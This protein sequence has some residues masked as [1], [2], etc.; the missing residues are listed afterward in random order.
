MGIYYPILFTYIYLTFSIIRYAKYYNYCFI[1]YI[2]V[3]CCMYFTRVGPEMAWKI[4]GWKILHTL[5]SQE[6]PICAFKSFSCIS[7]EKKGTWSL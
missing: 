4:M 7:F 6:L 3:S 5:F 2:F 1:H